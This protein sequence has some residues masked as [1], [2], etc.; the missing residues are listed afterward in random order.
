MQCTCPECFTTFDLNKETTEGTFIECP[1]C[2]LTL[3]VTSI[4]GNIAEVKVVELD[5]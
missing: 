4:N 5:K 3:M 1:N 2:A